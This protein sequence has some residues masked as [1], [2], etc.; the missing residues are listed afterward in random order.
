A[1]G[2]IYFPNGSVFYQDV[3]E[4][5][6]HADSGATIDYLDGMGG[7]G[8]GELR[9]DFSIEVLA[10]GDAA[11]MRAF[12]PTEDHYS[13]DCDEVEVPVPPGGALE[14]EDGYACAGDGDCHLIVV[15]EASMQLY[16]MWRADI[17]GD[18][19]RGGCLAVWDMEKVYGPEGRGYNCT[20]ADAAGLPIAPLLFSADEVAAG[21]IDHAIRFI[22]PNDRIR[23]G[24]FVA[25]GTHSTS[26][27]SGDEV[28]PPFGAR[29]R[30][31]ADYDLGDLR[32]GARVVAEA[33]QRYGLI[34]ADGGT[35]AL[36]AQS[37]RFTSEKWD[38]LLQPDDLAAIPITA[39]EVVDLGEMRAYD[40][41]CQR[42]E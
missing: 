2:G 15:D 19:F 20:S 10:A 23:G 3:S 31:R 17:D 28:A 18:T 9:I 16:E 24:V 30:L 34:L 11:E 26:A 37:D 32:P 33:M 41:D 12:V 39:F 13:P 6:L 36:T 14:G 5:P 22:L 40:G 8:G 27:A 7:W 25:P 21:S 29:L 42:V 1:P 4:A 35:I 38:G